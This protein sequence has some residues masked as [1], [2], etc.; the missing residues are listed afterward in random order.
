MIQC[1]YLGVAALAV[2]CLVVI[3]GCSNGRTE[4]AGAQAMAG[5]AAGTAAVS[6]AAQA[7]NGSGMT[8]PV[9]R[10]RLKRSALAQ[11]VKL[12]GQLASFEEVSIF[13]KVNGYVKDVWVDVGSHVKKG[14]LLME[15]EAPELQQATT[16]AKERYAQAKLDATISEQNYERMRQAAETPGAVSPMNLASLKAKADADS[17][18]CNAEK[19]NWQMQE[20]ILS[21]LR[22]TAPFDGVISE[23][24]VHPGALVSAESRDSKPMLEL[25]Q[26]NHLRLQVDIP[27]GIA[28]GLQ[29]KDTVIF[30]LS[31]YPGQKMTGH[32]ARR[33]DLVNST[34][35]AERME[36]DV[37][38]HDGKLAPGM[39]ADVLFDSKGNPS[40]FTVPK[41]AVVTSTE[42]KYVIAIRAGKMVKIDVATGNES[43]SEVEITGDLQPGEEVVAK[44]NDETAP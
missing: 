18:L 3:G 42:R 39:Y 14:Q 37:Y 1:K 15:L 11:L 24:N 19:A 20:A 12:P 21:Y 26:V 16:Q 7:G 22:V 8:A 10:V 31:A 9:E 6:G 41:T 17:A 35:R 40:A 34:Y 33:S 4:P 27:E 36:M 25:R 30:Y 28:A 23:R 2:C 13:P 5:T 29:D 32:I 38:N 43:A 44:A